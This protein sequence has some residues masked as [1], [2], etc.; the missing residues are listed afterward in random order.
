V[1]KTLQQSNW[2]QVPLS[3][4]QLLYAAT[5]AYVYSK[6]YEKVSTTAP[7][8]LLTVEGTRVEGVPFQSVLL[9]PFHGMKRI[10]KMLS[11]RHPCLW[12][13][14]QAFSNA[15]FINDPLDVKI[16]SDYLEK[17]EKGVSFEQKVINNPE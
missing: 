15:M 17:H 16:T 11:R 12:S 7:P 3:E 4:S 8:L 13:F 9:D 2:D 10:S 14:C 6:I 5:D 1:V